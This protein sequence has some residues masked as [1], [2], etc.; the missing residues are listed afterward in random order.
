MKLWEETRKIK[1]IIAVSMLREGWDVKNIAV[2]CLF[3]KFS[4]QKKGD[5]IHTVY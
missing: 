1:V 3:R 5:Q 2:I 4:Y